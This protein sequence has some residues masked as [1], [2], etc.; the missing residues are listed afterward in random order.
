MRRD[1]REDEQKREPEGEAE[2]H[3][4]QGNVSCPPKT[5][6]RTLES[7]PTREERGDAPGGPSRSVVSA[8]PTP[9]SASS[10]SGASAQPQ[11]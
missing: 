8:E 5:A 7:A 1:E 6:R 2:A 9:S 3:I 11:P 4:T 10:P